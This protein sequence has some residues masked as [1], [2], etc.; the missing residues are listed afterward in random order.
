MAVSTTSSTER[1][2]ADPL[3]TERFHEKFIDA[4]DSHRPEEVISLL[5]ED[6]VYDDSSWPAQ[7]HGHAEVRAFLGSTW[8][9]A[10]DLEL[11]YG[12]E[13]GDLLL[14]QA[15]DRSARCWHAK[16]THTGTWDPPGLAPTGRRFSF[17]GV[18]VMEMSGEKI[19]RIRVI[20]DVADI[21]R[22]LGVLPQSKS[23]GERLI[24]TAANLRS[25]LQ[26]R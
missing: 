18:T 10:P 4:W 9:A 6:V 22:Q 20:Y 17:H 19:A 14:D 12:P 26:R 1:H 5:T 7:M 21:M 11:T 8:R 23:T 16:G 24:I 13:D 3:S 15:A 25:R 2:G